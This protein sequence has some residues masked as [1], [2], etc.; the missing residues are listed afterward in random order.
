MKNH[1][2]IAGYTIL[3]IFV[4]LAIGCSSSQVASEGDANY[5]NTMGAAFLREGK[6]QLAYVEF[7]KAIKIE[8]DNKDVNN[9][10]GLTCFQLE[11]YENAKKYLL[12]AV[13]IAPDFP[14]A[15]N[16]L[17]VTYMQ[18]GQWREAA[19]SFRRA[20]AN[21]F[22]RTPELAFYSLGM[23]QYRMGQYEKALDS[24]KDSVRRDRNFAGPYYGMA[25]VY[26]RLERYG[27]ASEL[28]E[29]AIQTDVDFK[30]DKVKKAANL[31]ERSYTAKGEE[32]KDIRDFLD[33]MQY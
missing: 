13:N 30:G 6:I 10:L 11:D 14:D 23:A 7:Q 21:P 28:L 22:Y 20:I 18:I 24:F 31:R 8:P 15:H 9:N 26:N 33:I 12:R 1:T 17:G 32:E 29:K 2:I 5:H 3:T 27:E 25:L 19:E 4:A 16:N